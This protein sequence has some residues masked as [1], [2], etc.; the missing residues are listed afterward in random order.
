MTGAVLHVRRGG[1]RDVILVID[2]PSSLQPNRPAER[3]AAGD[4]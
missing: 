1:P 2:L 4:H 3:L